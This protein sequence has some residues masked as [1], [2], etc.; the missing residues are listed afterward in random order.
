MIQPTIPRRRG[1]ANIVLQYN[2]TTSITSCGV[3]IQSSSTNYTN[4]LCDGTLPASSVGLAAGRAIRFSTGPGCVGS[5]DIA[6]S[7]ASVTGT[8]A[9]NGT[10]VDSI[11]ICNVGGM[12]AALEFFLESNNSGF[13]ACYA[14][15]CQYNEAGI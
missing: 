5:P 2:T 11:Q 12:S 14:D 7:A 6:F 8:A 15:R 4:Y 9:L 1:D 10:D 13:D 3:G